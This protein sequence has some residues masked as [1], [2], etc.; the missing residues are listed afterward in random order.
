MKILFC[1]YGSGQAEKTLRFGA[2]IAAALQA[3]VSILGVTEKAGDEDALMQSLQNEGEILKE[4]SLEAELVTR[5]GNPERE[6]V[7]HTI[8]THYD[9]VVI[10]AVCKNP[11]RRLLD[12]WWISVRAYR[13]HRII[14]S[15]APPVLVVFCDRPALHRILLCTNADDYFDDAI[16]F[17]SGIAQAVNAAVNLFH[18]MPEPPAMYADLIRLEDDTDR[19]LESNSKLGRILRHQKDLLEQSGVFGQIRLRHGEVIP[20][21]LKELKAIE[22]D[23]VVSGTPRS[24][25]KLQR[26]VMGNVAREIAHRAELPVLVL[27][28]GQGQIA[29]YF[30]GFLDKLV[31]RSRKAPE[32]SQG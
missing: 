18:V 30:K 12:P 2:R 3:E 15:A 4:Y 26:Y 23:L 21:L 6:I 17:T 32:T 1:S 16:Q 7:N 29:H 14:E 9:L 5:V 19:V 11:F 31:R 25:S 24:E 13:A 10:G 8:E 20:E 22:Y 28:T 27:R